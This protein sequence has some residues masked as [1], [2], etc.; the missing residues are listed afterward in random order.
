MIPDIARTLTEAWPD[1]RGWSLNGNSYD[2]LVWPE[3][4][5]GP[6]PRYRQIVRAWQRLL[7]EEHPKEAA[8]AELAE[9]DASLVRVVEDV[10]DA[11]FDAGIPLAIQPETEALIARRKAL[12]EK[13]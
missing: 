9:T 3:D 5:L 12:R 1:K 10:V 7:A 4:K 11:L 13:L 6:K 8:K 2:G